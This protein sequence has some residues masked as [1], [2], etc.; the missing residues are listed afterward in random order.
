M[1]KIS[2]TMVR[3]SFP[4]ERINIM[5]PSNYRLTFLSIFWPR[6]V[7]KRRRRTK[8]NQTKKKKKKKKKKK[9][10]SVDLSLIHI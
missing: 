5:A 1:V 2:T 4:K 8:P 7:R 3:H 10:S 6:G 9:S